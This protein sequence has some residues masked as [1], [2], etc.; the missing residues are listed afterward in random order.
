LSIDGQAMGA[1]AVYR[2]LSLANGG[3]WVAYID[4]ARSQPIR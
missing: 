1:L 2:L 4:F 3:P